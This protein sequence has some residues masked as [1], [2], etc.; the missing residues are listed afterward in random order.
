MRIKLEG[1]PVTDQDRAL[2]FYTEKLGFVKKQDMDLG[3]GS[4]FLTLVSP[5][6]PDGTE[7]MLEPSGEHAATKAYKSALYAEKIPQTAFEVDDI[8]SQYERLTGLGVTFKGPPSDMGGS[9]AAMLD[10]TCGNWIMLYERP[11]AP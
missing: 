11:A 4:R 2:A 9:M 10:D 5:D 7:L 1:V 3:P 6:E 8:Q